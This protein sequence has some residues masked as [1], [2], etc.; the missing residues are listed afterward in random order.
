MK[1]FILTL[2]LSILSYLK[3]ECSDLDS[4]ECVQWSQY[5]EWDEDTDQ[6]TEIGG[7]GGNL[8]Y[9]PFDFSYLT[10]SDGIR[11][12]PDYMNGLLYYPTGINSPLK[13]II[14]TPGWGGESTSMTGWA[15]YFASYGFIAMAIGPNDV[16]NDTH[17]M[18]AEGLIDAIET[19][20][21]KNERKNFRRDSNA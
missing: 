18:R 2:S 15:E 19:I 14:F 10:E 16:E 6:C 21:Q 5:C 12:G 9:G 13:S 4:T 3:A 11:N 8:D 17:E 1:I 7:G 20:K